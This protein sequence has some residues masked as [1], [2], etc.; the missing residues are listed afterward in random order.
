MDWLV[1]AINNSGSNVILNDLGITIA[2]TASITLSDYFSFGEIADSMDLQN[3]VAA[4]SLTINNGT[5]DLSVANGVKYVTR[6]NLYN[7]LTM[8][9]TKAE[10]STPSGGGTVDWSNIVNAPTYG[11][12]T[13]ITPV[14]YNV[15]KIA[16][17]APASPLTGEV[18]IKTG[19]N[20]YYKWNGTAWVSLGS[21]VTGD[22]VINFGSIPP[23]VNTF[24]G[25][26]WVASPSAANDTAV[27]VNYDGGDG[28]NA[29]N[30][31]Y[32]F[33]SSSGTWIKIGDVSF[34]N[35]LNG[36]ADKHTANQIDVT[37]TYSNIG[38]PANV[39][40]MMS[41]INAELNIALVRETLDAAYRVGGAGAGRTINADGGA[42]VMDTLATT[43]A[44]LQLTPKASLPTTGLAAGQLAVKNNMLC[45]YDSTRA[46]WLS[47]QRS[48]FAF[49]RSGSTKNQYL[50]FF[51]G[52][53]VSNLSGLLMPY[54]ATIVSISGQLSA[55]GTCNMD[56]R[57][58]NTAT[59]SLILALSTVI[60]ASSI[61]SNL[62]MNA[63]DLMQAF[64]DTTTAGV[65]NPIMFVEVAW[66]P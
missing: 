14:L 15:L 55:I 10:L 3:A 17:S 29:V 19:D 7:D 45:I 60:G 28:L 43:T 1:I 58:N 30:A 9:Y 37:G 22:R 52:N 38:G 46:K 16:A 42:V 32:V 36:G 35:H 20:N 31:Q 23:V 56:I 57:L 47:V 64:L 65:S 27:M 18:Y 61:S 4:G 50:S 34:T 6:D 39:E 49:G 25:T 24:N 21:A 44:P 53:V 41:N 8:H 51:A 13:W 11:A 63:G 26:T 33:Q 5:I 40:T 2:N 62:D 54:N 66:R 59:N 48:T 12:P